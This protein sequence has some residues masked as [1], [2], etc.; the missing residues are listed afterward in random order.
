MSVCWREWSS[1][2][3]KADDVG[4]NPQPREGEGMAFAVSTNTSCN[5]RKVEY[6]CAMLVD[7]WIFEAR[8]MWKFSADGFSFL[9][10]A[11]CKVFSC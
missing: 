3:G 11:G 6:V 9:K 7:V 1:S 5:D 4:E 2:G 10:G 8:R